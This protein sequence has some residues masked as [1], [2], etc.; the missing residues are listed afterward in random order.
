MVR[1]WSAGCRSKYMGCCGRLR[2]IRKPICI[3]GELCG[4]PRPIMASH[5]AARNAIWPK[6]IRY[7]HCRI[8]GKIGSWESSL[9]IAC[10]TVCATNFARLGP[11]PNIESIS[12][13]S[14]LRA[15]CVSRLF[16]LLDAFHEWNTREQNSSLNC[17]P[18]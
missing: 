11:G 3:I 12:L 1:L 4:C 10:R 17:K 13:K 15:L 8:D 7:S 5:V 16:V 9:C 14:R 18:S 6:L 2:F